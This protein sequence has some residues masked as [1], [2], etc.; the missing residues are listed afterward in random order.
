MRTGRRTDRIEVNSR[1]SRFFF[2]RAYKN[3]TLEDEAPV[4]NL[5]AQSADQQGNI[6]VVLTV[7]KTIVYFDECSYRTR[8]LLYTSTI[9][10][11]PNIQR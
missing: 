10:I 7:E 11:N 6:V 3:E 9:V 1:F 5:L 2:E 8:E 4:W